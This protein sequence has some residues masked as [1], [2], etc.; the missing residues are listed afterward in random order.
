[1][2]FCYC[3]KAAHLGQ[4]SVFRSWLDN[5]WYWR[6]GAVQCMCHSAIASE[7]K[8][9]LEQCMVTFKTVIA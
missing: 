5:A 7:V 6:F 8:L 3:W 2:N 1:M 4:A 9:D